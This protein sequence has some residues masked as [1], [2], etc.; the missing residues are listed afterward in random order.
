MSRVNSIIKYISD[1]TLCKSQQ[2]LNYFGETK[3][4]D[5]GICSICIN[6]N[7]KDENNIE[8]NGIEVVILLLQIE[9][10]TSRELLTK[11][12]L[13]EKQLTETIQL[14]LEKNAITLTNYNTYKLVQ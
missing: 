6:K 7:K 13:S 8:A 12:S 2:L 14:L 9:D 4:S 1:D 10:L 3:T 5:C 11:S